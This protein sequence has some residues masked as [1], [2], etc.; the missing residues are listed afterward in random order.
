L[1]ATRTFAG[2]FPLAGGGEPRDA[3]YITPKM[4][5]KLL[6]ALLAG[7]KKGHKLT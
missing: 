1:P 3:L 2:V 4:P 5:E 6:A 7:G